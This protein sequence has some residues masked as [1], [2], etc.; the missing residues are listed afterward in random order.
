MG[1]IRIMQQYNDC[2]KRVLLKRET[3]LYRNNLGGKI[4][5]F[6]NIKKGFFLTLLMLTLLVGCNS[7]SSA[8]SGGNNDSPESNG[9]EE[10]VTGGELKVAYSA[11]PPILDPATSNAIVTAEIMGHVYETLI[12]TDADYNI[13]P[14][15]A[16]SFEQSEDGK[17]VTFNLRQGILFHNGQEMKADDVVASLNKWKEGPGGRGQFDDA[18]FEAEDD[19]TVVL[20]LAEPLST[21]LFAIAQGG[22][23]FSAIMPKDIAEA[24]GADGATEYIGTGP[25]KFVEWRQDQ[26]IHLAKFDDY[27]PLD[28]PANGL[29]GKR[30]ALVDDLY[31]MIVTDS[32]TRV[33]GIQ[34]GEYDFAHEIPLDNV[35]QL[36]SNP[37]IDTHI[38]P[39]AGSITGIL[40]KKKGFFT[41]VKAREG[42]YAAL[43][44]GAMM[45]A[46]LTDEKYYDLNHNLMLPHQA[47]QWYSDTG[48]D[49]YNVQD[50]DKAKQLFSEAGYNG[51]EIRI[52]TSRDYDHIYNAS[53]V[54]ESQLEQA[55]LNVK[56]EVYDWATLLSKLNDEDSFDIFLVWL[57]FKPEPTSLHV[58]SKDNSGWTDSEE[59]N[60]ILKEFRSQPTI[61]DAKPV[62]EKLQQWNWEYFPA[63]KI[64]DYN[65]VDA[66]RDYVKNLQYLDRPIF[67][68]VS[69]DK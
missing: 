45:Q 13:K 31:F 35:E 15:L 23:S 3:K 18:V 14:M 19:Y 25:F 34:S 4:M 22:S 6:R 64:G 29:A 62:Y 9:A 7:N 54:M 66:T 43:D 63:V 60:E 46:A 11:Q 36:E 5:S 52:V 41:D 48:K 12:T 49:I 20:K 10:V 2:K 58:L 39:G 37:N 26:Y 51:E 44:M 61:E 40:N 28:E 47:E 42:L 65:K 30:E 38:V 1:I 53:V 68:N 59:L 55:G 32:S 56:L 8:P 27:Q 21:A 50:V 67:W 69:V 24:A 57:G 33:A 17:T 16:E